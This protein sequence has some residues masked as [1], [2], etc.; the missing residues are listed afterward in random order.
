ME[1]SVNVPVA[2]GRSALIVGADKQLDEVLSGVLADR[3]WTVWHVH[4]NQAALS[5]LKAQ[6][7]DLVVTGERTSGMEDVELLRKIRAAHPH[8][9]VIILTDDSTPPDVLIS[10]REHAFSYFSQPFSVESV[11]DMVRIAMDQQCWDDGIEVL[12]ATP[13]WIS[14]HVRCDQPTANRLVQFFHE[15]TV[16]PAPEKEAVAFAFREMLMNAM[17]HGARFDPSQY[18]EVSYIRGRR[19]VA[20]RVKDPG[21]GFTLDELHHA[22]ISNPE[23][24]PIRH[25]TYREAAGLPPGGYGILLSRHMVDELIYGE[26]GNDVLLV[27]YLDVPQAA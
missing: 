10:M 25:V 15:I 27:K 17:R 14:L 3:G 6:I 22:A 21:E 19:M 5:T 13:A 8:T 16:L 12:S 26:R 4:N 2:N 7:I 1:S 11:A 18:V 20:C 9:R 23:D 24:N